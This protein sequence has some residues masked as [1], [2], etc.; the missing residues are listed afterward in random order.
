MLIFRDEEVVG[1]N[2]ATPTVECLV[3]GRSPVLEDGLRHARARA[4]P[5]D[6]TGRQPESAAPDRA[7]ALLTRHIRT[8]VRLLFCEEVV[9]S[10]SLSQTLPSA[11]ALESLTSHIHVGV[12]IDSRTARPQRR[13]RPVTAR[14]S[15]A[16]M[17]RQ[18]VSRSHNERLPS[19]SSCGGV[20]STVVRS[21]PELTQTSISRKGSSPSWASP[22]PQDLRDR[23]VRLVLE[24]KDQYPSER[25]AIKHH[26]LHVIALTQIRLNGEHTAYFSRQLAAGPLRPIGQRP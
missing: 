5:T 18:L 26:T 10:S 23:A 17:L 22:Y 4:M 3:R 16:R 14:L 6:L 12:P 19:S 21:A 25:P 11:V 24:T 15:P 20:C 2:P 1:S 9:G 8:S 7:Y 13:S